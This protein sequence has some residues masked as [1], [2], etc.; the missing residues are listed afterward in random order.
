MLSVLTLLK[1]RAAHGL[2]SGEAVE[3]G[4]ADPADKLVATVEIICSAEG[5]CLQRGLAKLVCTGLAVEILN[6]LLH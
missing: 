5:E 6:V 4:E 2:V 1:T 3:T